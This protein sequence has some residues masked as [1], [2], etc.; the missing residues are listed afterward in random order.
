MRQ[1]TPSPTDTSTDIAEM[2]EQTST[3]ED[4]LLYFFTRIETR[5]WN[6]VDARLKEENTLDLNSYQVLH[7]IEKNPHCRPA[8]ISAELSVSSGGVTKLLDRLEKEGY[9]RRE[10]NEN[11]RRSSL[12]VLT[13]EGEKELA[14]SHELVQQTVTSILGHVRTLHAPDDA[15]AFLSVLNQFNQVLVTRCW[16]ED[17]TEG[18]AADKGEDKA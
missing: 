9:L 1:S 3:F 11:D 12:I 13:D 18:E 6:S 16:D 8:D 15:D 2:P 14:H 5:L 10:A 4:A 17:H 7:A